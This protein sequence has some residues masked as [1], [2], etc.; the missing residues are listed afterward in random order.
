MTAQRLLLPSF[1]VPFHFRESQ[2]QVHQRPSKQDISQTL[3]GDTG[4]KLVTSNLHLSQSNDRITCCDKHCKKKN[5]NQN[6]PKQKTLKPTKPNRDESHVT[7][8]PLYIL[9]GFT[10]LR[11]M[12]RSHQFYT[13][14]RRFSPM[15]LVVRKT[16]YVQ[17]K[18]H[19]IE[20]LPKVIF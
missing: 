5:P 7:S 2:V 20:K 9:L 1:P 11:N 13:T 16:L 19:L 10:S 15:Q 6:K 8:L 12:P 3:W 4:M 17:E 14:Y 18:P